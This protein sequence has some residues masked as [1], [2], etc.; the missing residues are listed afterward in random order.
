MSRDGVQAMI[1]GGYTP[2]SDFLTVNSYTAEVP[3]Y[4]GTPDIEDD[5][6]LFVNGAFELSAS[7][8]IYFF[9]NYGERN[10]EGGV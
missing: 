5:I 2:P 4:W 7:A 6:K 1:D 9:G 8:E 3:H 10:V